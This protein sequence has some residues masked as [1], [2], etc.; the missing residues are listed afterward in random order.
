MFVGALFFQWNQLTHFQAQIHQNQPYDES[1]EVPDGEEIA[2]NY[3]PTPRV[4][5]Q[6][7]L[8]MDTLTQIT[9]TIFND[10][11]SLES[12]AFC[13]DV[14]FQISVSPISKYTTSA[15]D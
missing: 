6:G 2:S 14:V 8:Q 1:L 13:K 9:C 3:S 15:F 5:K 7:M 10:F 4:N 11:S 12:C